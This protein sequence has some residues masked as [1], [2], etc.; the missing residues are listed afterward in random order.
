MRSK[1]RQCEWKAE[2][3]RDRLEKRKR[4]P[5][6]LVLSVGSVA[7]QSRE[8]HVTLREEITAQGSLD[9]HDS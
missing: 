9:F 3:Q 1:E 8:S 5:A 2:R 6:D 7:S 4:V